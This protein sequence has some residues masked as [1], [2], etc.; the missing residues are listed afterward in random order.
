M[1]LSIKRVSVIDE[2]C[3]GVLMD[4]FVPFA[5][6]LERTYANGFV[7]IPPGTYQCVKD[8]Y[9]KGGYPTFEIKVPGH[10]RILFHKANI[11]DD[12]DGCIAI[13]EQ[14]GELRGK[15]GILQSG[16]G[17]S[18]FWNKVKDLESFTITIS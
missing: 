9:H 3:F 6:T 15:P 4:N 10:S 8:Y 5:L 18:E 12:L 14:F 13:G 1:N 2:G 16:I 7:K 11:E 17:F